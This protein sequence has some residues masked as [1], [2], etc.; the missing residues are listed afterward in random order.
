MDISI[1]K[2][3]FA[4]IATEERSARRT[5]LESSL[6]EVLF[7]IIKFVNEKKDHIPPVPTH[8]VVFPYEMT[9]PRYFF[10]LVRSAFW[11][12]GAENK[13]TDALTFICDNHFLDASVL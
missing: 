8:D 5:A 6:R 12:Y 10:I 11:V 13:D 3:I 1:I 4:D 7:D 9:I 2:C